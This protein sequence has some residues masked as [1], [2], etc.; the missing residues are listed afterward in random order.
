MK[1]TNVKWLSISFFFFWTIFLLIVH[2]KCL[3]QS[4]PACLLGREVYVAVFLLPTVRVTVKSLV[5]VCVCVCS[6][7]ELH[8]YSFWFWLPFVWLSSFPSLF[9][10]LILAFVFLSSLFSSWS[11]S[12]SAPFVDHR[13]DSLGGTGLVS[14]LFFRSP[15][16]SK[17]VSC[18]DVLSPK[19]QLLWYVYIKK[20]KRDCGYRPEG[21]VD[22]PRKTNVYIIY[23]S[24]LWLHCD[25]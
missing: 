1:Y 21:G 18:F 25:T 11:W 2:Q 19:Q 8:Q 3:R 9:F 5:C 16:A 10:S 23:L 4:V 24:L 6:F 13:M 14:R 20:E 15:H 17:R 7:V 22:F 12:W